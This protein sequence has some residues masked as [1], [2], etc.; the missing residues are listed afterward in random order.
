MYTLYLRM[1]IAI[2]CILGHYGM[3]LHDSARGV[4]FG[5]RYSSCYLIILGLSCSLLLSLMLLSLL[6]G[7][8]KSCN[9]TIYMYCARTQMPILAGEQ[10]V[11]ECM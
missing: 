9:S 11:R 10:N 5:K 7:L 6:A 8:G 2:I 3:Y 1:C 4:W